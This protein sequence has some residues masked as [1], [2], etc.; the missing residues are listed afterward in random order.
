MKTTNQ[1]KKGV[2]YARVSS[3]RQEKEGFSIPAQ[4]KFLHEYAK[5]NNIKIVA[6]F[7]ESE[8]AKKSGR[9]EFDK[10]IKFIKKNKSVNTILVEKTDRLYRNLKDYVVLDE[11]K[12]LEIHLVKE[13]TILSEHSRS[14]DKFMHGIRVLMAKNYIDNLSE[15]VKKG[16]NEKAE[17]GFFPSKAP[18][19]YT[20]KILK[21]GKRIIIV[22]DDI[23][24]YIKQIFQLYA[25]NKYTYITLAKKMTADGF[26]PNGHNC[27]CKNIERILNNPFYIGRFV[28]KG[29]L[30]L[31][32]QHTP[33]IDENVYFH[34]QNI[35]RNKYPTKPTKR[36]FIYNGLIRCKNC[37]CQL[38]GEIKKGKY[39][40][41]H[42]TN[43]KGMDE[44]KPSIR[45]EKIDELFLIFLEQVHFTP[46]QVSEIKENVKGFINQG[47]E[48]IENK[49][50]ELKK[51]IDL[52]NKRIS[53]LY[54]DRT[55][56]IITDEFYYE[57]RDAWQRELDDVSFEF[58]Q[59]ATSSK[60]LINDA[61]IIIE[62][63]KD[64][65]SLFL[66]ATGKE[67][68]ELMKL[69]TIELLF[70]GQNVLIT[71]HS[72]F[73]NLIQLSNCHKLGIMS[74][75]SNFYVQKFIESLS[76]ANFV[77][78]IKTYKNVA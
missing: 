47:C 55:D 12:D 2:L 72:A 9:A 20:N 6:E 42:C 23:A 78:A 5:Q 21:S 22:D 46:E 10:M 36:E 48:Y 53:K 51:R 70:D 50:S 25:T 44:R 69:L 65:K 7:I 31:N 75:S 29:K 45:E 8:T 27:S 62:L 19:G 67:K 52:L 4:I 18:F 3:D 14:Q 58:S 40:Y 33:L 17:Q 11:L 57:K 61:E 39:I 43:A 35:M 32:G 37:G 30:Y 77:S 24:P 68:A 71:P 41:Y 60:N 63:A 76:D 15:E 28:Y 16:L 74:V 56:G 13:S 1:I 38:V 64:A 34:C 66:S 49:T 54:D 73:Y 59:T 26:R